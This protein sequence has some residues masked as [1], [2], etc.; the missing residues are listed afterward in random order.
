MKKLAY[1]APWRGLGLG[2]A[3]LTFAACAT[4]GGGS[5]TGSEEKP[6]DSSQ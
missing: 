1:L 5:P 4:V 6:D 3:T 2:V